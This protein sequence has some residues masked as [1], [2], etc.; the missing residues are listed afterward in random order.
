MHLVLLLLRGDLID[1]RV[2]GAHVLQLLL[3]GVAIRGRDLRPKLIE[4]LACLGSNCLPKL[5]IKGPRVVNS[6]HLLCH[7]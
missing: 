4:Y 1:N 5:L 6:A 7:R 2:N 3:N